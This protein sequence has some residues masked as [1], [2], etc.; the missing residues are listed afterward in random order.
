MPAAKR[1]PKPNTA[2]PKG[3]RN[4]AQGSALGGGR[5]SILFCLKGFRPPRGLMRSQPGGLP[6]PY[7]A[8]GEI[9]GQR[10]FKFARNSTRSRS[11]ALVRNVITSS[12]IADL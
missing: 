4:P 7:L 11:S 2:C 9:L 3:C 1:P 8:P 12:V 5:L 6:E 10:Y